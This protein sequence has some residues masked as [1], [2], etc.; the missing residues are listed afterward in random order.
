MLHGAIFFLFHITEIKES[1]PIEV[2][3]AAIVF[4]YD[5][6]PAFNW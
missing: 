5:R 1:D 3:E 6:E 2:S 4:K